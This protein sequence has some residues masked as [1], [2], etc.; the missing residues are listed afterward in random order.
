MGI[1]NDVQQLTV[2]PE[3]NAAVNSASQAYTVGTKDQKLD[4][5]H[6][7]RDYSFTKIRFFG[8]HAPTTF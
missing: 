7:A 4:A 3:E 2:L 8:H 1:L 5:A 6:S